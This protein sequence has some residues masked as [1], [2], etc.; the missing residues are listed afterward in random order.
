M[1]S[2]APIPDDLWQDLCRLRDSRDMEWLRLV[3]GI[4]GS[5]LYRMF[6]NR[7]D[8]CKPVVHNHLRWVVAQDWERNPPA[9]L[10]RCA[11]EPDGLTKAEGGVTPCPAC[12]PA[13]SGGY[14]EI[15]LPLGPLAPEQAG[16]VVRDLLRRADDLRGQWEI[17]A[18]LTLTQLA[19]DLRYRTCTR[20]CD[21]VDLLRI[22]TKSAELSRRSVGPSQHRDVYD[23]C[24]L[25]AARLLRDFAR[26]EGDTLPVAVAVPVVKELIALENESYTTPTRE[27]WGRRVAWLRTAT[28]R[29]AEQLAAADQ[30]E[31]DSVCRQLALSQIPRSSAG[32]PAV[33][34]P[35][36]RVR[37]ATPLHFFGLRNLQAIEFFDRG[38]PAAV[39][40]ALAGDYADA[41]QYIFP[42]DGSVVANGGERST[43][44][45]MSLYLAV[46]L[47]R[48]RGSG[49]AHLA[50]AECLEDS[51][52]ISAASGC[53][54]RC[55]VTPA[56]RDAAAGCQELADYLCR[57][58]P[59]PPAADLA[60][61]T[62]QAWELIQDR[63]PKL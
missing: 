24:V 63:L 38:Q 16:G 2:T 53:R 54:A 47:W 34:S 35:G 28:T 12:E 52:R 32:R 46:A 20:F 18:A 61:R 10:P 33:P 9:P 29:H 36:E 45:G 37:L 43:M 5:K 7:A 40:A 41:R 42:T 39:V 60:D 1:F 6:S 44:M 25:P 4:S 15:R 51:R 57:V 49:R 17:D 59:E 27:G 50:W 22:A 26:D 8:K 19:Y 11:K 55:I 23:R 48:S 31:L 56:V 13:R 58:S 30:S 14:A 21:A 62:E 3:S